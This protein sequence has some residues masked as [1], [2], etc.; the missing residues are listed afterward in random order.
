MLSRVADSLYWM[1]RNIERAETNARVL[2]VQLIHMLEVSEQHVSNRDWEEIIEISASLSD[3]YSGHDG[4][5]REEVIHYLTQDRQNFNSISNCMIYARENAKA[6]RDMIPDG[7]WEV[8]NQYYLEHTGESRFSSYQQAQHAL[9]LTMQTSTTAQ[10]I[11]ESSMTRGVPY[12]FL[13][14]GK[15]LE[16]AEK[17]ARIL[18][19]LCE[20]TLK[21]K[22]AANVSNY[23]YWL[24][25]LQQVNGYNAYI[26]EY[27]PTMK[28]EHVLSFIIDN[29]G[30]PR[31]IRYCIDHVME[32]IHHLED[33]KI[34]HYSQQ[35]FHTLATVQE[36][37]T[38][39]HID[40]M[41]TEELMAFLD[42][43]QNRCQ[44]MSRLFSETYYLIDPV[45]IK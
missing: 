9:Q 25:A 40:D 27:P 39:A 28:P 42:R 13:K 44:E 8:L 43:F 14:I 38:A 45:K 6:T 23:Y 15:W 26:K 1:A 16:R 32:A 35:L 3:Y 22:Q 33:G 12:A 10:G 37:F 41:S 20:K 18:N 21:E 17:T 36:E 30:F 4:I 5:E 11:V 29:R 31:S 7:L 19:V 24:T 2:S 34:S